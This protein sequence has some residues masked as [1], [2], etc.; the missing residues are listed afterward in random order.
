MTTID[1]SVFRVLCV[2]RCTLHNV[3]RHPLPLTTTS[4]F[5][6]KPLFCLHKQ[7]GERRAAGGCGLISTSLRAQQAP[8]HR[9][10]IECSAFAFCWHS[11]AD[12]RRQKEVLSTVSHSVVI[13]LFTCLWLRV[14]F[15][16]KNLKPKPEKQYQSK[17]V[18]C[19]YCFVFLYIT[20]RL[21]YEGAEV[22]HKAPCG[23]CKQSVHSA[24]CNLFPSG[25]VC[26]EFNTTR[27]TEEM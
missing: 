20:K 25:G 7:N 3:F 24:A 17:N 18:T 14:F 11:S 13:V 8:Q 4:H 2:W 15:F 16:V 12:P 1:L 26:R 9:P 10:L 6:C 19:F 22:N 27:F 23:I 21:I 5:L